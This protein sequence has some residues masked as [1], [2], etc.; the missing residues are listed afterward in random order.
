MNKYCVCFCRVSTQQQDL[1][2]QT[3]SIISEAERLGYDKDHQ[4][5]IEFKESGITLSSNERVGIERLKSEIN[6]NPNINCVI[7]WELSRIARRADVIYNIRDFFLERKIQWIVLHPKV[8][9][10]DENGKLSESSNIMLSVFTSFVENE[11]SIKKER[12]QRGK[13]RNRQL[14][15]YNGGIVQFGYSVDENGF[16][17]VCPKTSP[18]VS[19]MFKMYSTG[20]YTLL[21]LSREMKELGYFES[22][23]T[24][25]AIKTFLFKVL[26]QRNYYG[27]NHHPPI[28]SKELFDKVQEKLLQKRTERN[29]C[30]V[31]ERL[32]DRL[33][34]DEEGYMLSFRNRQE[35]SYNVRKGRTVSPIYCSHLLSGYRCSISQKTIDPFLWETSKELYKKHLMN[36]SRIRKTQTER[37]NTLKQKYSVCEK[38]IKEVQDKIDRSEER[39][40]NGKMRPEKLDLLIENLVKEKTELEG[41]CILLVEEM[42]GILEHVKQVI[43]N[44]SVD[45]DTLPFK[46]RLEIVQ[47]VIERVIVRRPKS[48]CYWATL[49]VLTKVNNSVYQYTIY[50]PPGASKSK[51]R[52]EKTGVRQRRDDDI[53]DVSRKWSHIPINPTPNVKKDEGG[54]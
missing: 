47:S 26:K 42:E 35:S 24:L 37:M 52:W 31:L 9:L 8:E 50:T 45:L 22:F 29:T 19:M 6:Q 40:I 17:K 53:K 14:G 44:K 3:N 32:G 25:P 5:V 16:L 39:Y 1:V 54:E 11:M 13:E 51:P 30:T 7:C 18:V 34:F 10:L 28:I 49:E 23:S 43:D 21:S 20:N 33:L 27:D 4:I 36:V 12:F 46:D 15:R 41:R 38:R 2:Q 48:G